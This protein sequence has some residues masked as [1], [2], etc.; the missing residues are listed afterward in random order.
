MYCRRNKPGL[1]HRS[2]QSTTQI[3][4]ESP[5]TNGDY[6]IYGIT[7]ATLLLNPLFLRFI[8]QT[9]GEKRCVWPQRDHL[10]YE[11]SG[12]RQVEP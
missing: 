10:L 6:G 8:I 3:I 11:S 5:E 2:S 9:L 12:D 4:L 1:R 7:R